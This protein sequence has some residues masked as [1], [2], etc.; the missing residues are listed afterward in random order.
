MG[1]FGPKEGIKYK[2]IN[3]DEEKKKKREINK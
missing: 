2:C 1:T 3:K